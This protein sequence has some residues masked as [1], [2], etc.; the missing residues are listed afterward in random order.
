MTGATRADLIP[1][2]NR[3]AV[4]A[5]TIELVA[6]GLRTPRGLQ[7]ALGLDPRTVQYYLQAGAWLG[8]LENNHDV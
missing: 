5:R 7:E 2:A 3:P 6:R 4:L 8:L 1:N